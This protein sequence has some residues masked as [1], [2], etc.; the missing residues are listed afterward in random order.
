MSC[1]VEACPLLQK[2]K[3]HLEL[4]ESFMQHLILL[5]SKIWFCFWVCQCHWHSS[6]LI[7]ITFLS[8]ISCKHSTTQN[9]Q[10]FC[11]CIHS[12]KYPT[13][14][15]ENQ[16]PTAIKKP[17]K[18]LNTK[19]INSW[20]QIVSQTKSFRRHKVTYLCLTW[21]PP[22]NSCSLAFLSMASWVDRLACRRQLSVLGT[23]THTHT[24]CQ[25]PYWHT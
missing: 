21:A 5:L 6:K 11:W 4:A 1:E 9:C 15:S 12:H 17:K 10:A 13:L 20:N 18:L 16:K 19:L 22:D 8:T 25:V 23:T 14:S 2:Q 7:I 24:Q 3:Q